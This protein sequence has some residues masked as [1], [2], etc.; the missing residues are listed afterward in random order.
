MNITTFQGMR[1]AAP[2]PAG[3]RAVLRGLAR[4]QHGS[5]VLTTPDGNTH[6]FGNGE[7]HATVHV[8]NW[9]ALSAALS[10]GD[11]GLAEG[12]MRG[13]WSTPSLT[14]LL[15]VLLR[16]RREIES[17][18]YG[19]GWGR[20][21]YRIQHLMN[22]N[23]RG[24]SRRNIQAHYDLGN[25]FYRLWL[26]ET[27]NYS[28]ALFGGDPTQP[29]VKAQDAKVRRALAA[30]GVG[31]GDRVMEIGCGWGALAE[32]GACEFGA[33]MHGVT[34]SEEQ[35]AYAA[36]RLDAAKPQF[37]AD[38]RLQD[39]R[40]IDDGPFDAVVSIEMLEA[41]GRAFW[42]GYF[43]KL[44]ALLKSG[45]HACI[46][47]IV[48]DEALWPRYIR[49][50]DFIQQYIFPGGCLPCCSEIERH[51]R[52]AGLEVVDEFSFGD[53]YAQTLRFWRQRFLAAR[54]EVLALGFDEAF[55]RL[56]DFYLAYCEVAFE[57]CNTDVV[58]Y[59]LRKR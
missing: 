51:A 15:G 20:F 17:L 30:A 9:N 19:S 26:D 37:R 45:G 6:R 59:T 27:M 24:G 3:A 22:R 12:Y 50:T 39:Y 34:L 8:R 44:A 2:P 36:Q 52:A 55:I 1:F 43:S 46:Q 48:M 57:Q 4:L 28:S 11:I 38:L 10:S 25:E 32:M 18:V 21:A 41:V 29:M 56:W 54:E 42:P 40:D 16:N 49:G 33:R 47:S 23:S 5:L 31:P 13:D 35:L 58:Q 53:D 14:E 7:Q